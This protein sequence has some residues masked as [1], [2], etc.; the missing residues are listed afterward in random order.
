[1][2]VDEVRLH[3]AGKFQEEIGLPQ[4]NIDLSR[5]L[6]PATPKLWDGETQEL[7]HILMYQAVK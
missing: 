4:S 6:F 3:P 7:K 1:M 2:W 5:P